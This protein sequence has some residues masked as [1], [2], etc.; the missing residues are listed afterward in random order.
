VKGIFS[1]VKVL[2]DTLVDATS[3]TT[4]H[5]ASLQGQIQNADPTPQIRISPLRPELDDGDNLVAHSAL[6]FAE[7]ELIKVRPSRFQ[8]TDLNE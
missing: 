6:W 2:G 1:S 3:S 7:S 4:Q 8:S 5:P